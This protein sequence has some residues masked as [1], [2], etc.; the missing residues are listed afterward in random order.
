M[1]ILQFEGKF[2]LTLLMFGGNQTIQ[3]KIWRY[4]RSSGK[5]MRNIGFETQML[6]NGSSYKYSYKMIKQRFWFKIFIDQLNKVHD[7][8]NKSKQYGWKDWPK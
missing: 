1:E 3:E 5:I 6:F 2:K 8:I 4:G 7:N